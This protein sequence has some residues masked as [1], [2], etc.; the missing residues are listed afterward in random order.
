MSEVVW[1]RTRTCREV[2][3][4][5]APQHRFVRAVRR[6]P[7]IS[8][9]HEGDFDLGSAGLHNGIGRR[10]VRGFYARSSSLPPTSMAILN[11]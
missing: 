10:L 5:A 2:A 3:N 11:T 6:G 7:A 1:R 9:A 4:F 8:I